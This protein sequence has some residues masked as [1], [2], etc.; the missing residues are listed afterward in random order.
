M[1]AFPTAKINL[2]LNITAKRSDGYHAIE[3]VFYPVKLADALELSPATGT[4][5]E[6][7][8][9]GLPIE[10]KQPSN[11]VFKAWEL[12]AERYGIGPIRAHLLKVIPMGAGLGGG[13]A[14]GAYMLRLLNMHFELGLDHSKL[15]RLA[16][17]LGSDCPFFIQNTPQLVTGRG[18]VMESFELDL[19]G[20]WLAL[21]NPGIHIGTAEA[22]ANVVPATPSYNLAAALQM[23]VAEWR[24][25]V[26]NQ[27]ETSVFPAHPELSAMKEQ[28]Y[29][30]G[31][32]YASMTGSGST[33][34][35]VFR[36]E[37]DAAALGDGLVW[38]GK[39]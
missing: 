22:Y 26:V 11:L 34:F 8:C 16:L 36:D 13:S 31:A 28:L 1:I 14:D 25:V 6:L 10:G 12:L 19:S 27:F 21:T 18:E 2:G 37:P 29:Q 20:Y 5:F 24:E 33:L 15:E 39:L 3:S 17:E 7:V 38:V 35:G 4:D 32:M 9:S 30:A 23:P